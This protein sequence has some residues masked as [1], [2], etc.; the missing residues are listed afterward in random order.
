[1]VTVSTNISASAN[2]TPWLNDFGKISIHYFNTGRANYIEGE[3]F[4]SDCGAIPHGGKKYRTL[5]E[6]TDTALLINLMNLDNSKVS[7]G[8]KVYTS[9]QYIISLPLERETE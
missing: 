6:K 5:Q 3:F 8:S 9:S 4:I 2:H 7:K 1:M